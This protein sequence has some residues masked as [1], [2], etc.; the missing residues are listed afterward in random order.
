VNREKP[1]KVALWLLERW[2]R[3]PKQESL[4]GDMLEQYQRGRSVAW[5]WRQTI[6]A[7]STSLAV[8]TWQHRWLAISVVVLSTYLPQI[9]MLT[10]PGWV[11][12]LDGLWYPHLISSQWSWMATNPWA[13]RLQLYFVTTRFTWCALL[14]TVAWIL[15]RVRPR[16]RGLVVTLLVIT[17]VSQCVPPMRVAVMD[18]MQESSNTIAFFSLLWFSTFTLIA[19]PLSILLGGSSGT[20]EI[21]TS[22]SV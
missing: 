15:T 18:W 7:I 3:S 16:Q 20:R 8:E 21:Q 19:V 12:R 9:Y 2:A 13:Y 22:R 4:V 1:P 11:A 5:Y 14:A 10:L 6:S 17:Q